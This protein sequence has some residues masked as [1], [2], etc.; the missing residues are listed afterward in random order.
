MLDLD[1]V[2]SYIFFYRTGKKGR[3]QDHILHV[4]LLSALKYILKKILVVGFSM[5]IKDQFLSVQLLAQC[6]LN[7]NL[8][9][10]TN[11]ECIKVMVLGGRV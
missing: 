4:A 10:S 2:L 7:L 1:Y 3:C 9:K 6:L 11:G 5:M 8:G